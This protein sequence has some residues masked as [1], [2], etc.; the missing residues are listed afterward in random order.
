MEIPLHVIL[1]IACSV[2]FAWYW[3]RR[4]LSSPTTVMLALCVAFVVRLIVLE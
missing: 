1:L 2:L 3:R 4:G